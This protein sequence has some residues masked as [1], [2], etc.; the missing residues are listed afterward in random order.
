[1][2]PRFSSAFR[3]L[4]QCSR[5][6]P[7]GAARTRNR[8]LLLVSRFPSRTTR[9]KTMGK[10]KTQNAHHRAGTLVYC[11]V[12]KSDRAE[13]ADLPDQYNVR[14]APRLDERL[15]MAAPRSG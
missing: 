2:V 10:T 8:A 7:S 12:C 11:I 14:A 13:S 5:L 9:L 4:G 1:M 15:R 6:V 3:H